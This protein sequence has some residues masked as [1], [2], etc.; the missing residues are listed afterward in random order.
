MDLCEEK[1]VPK[2][3]E[4]E[5][6]ILK[7]LARFQR[8]LLNSAVLKRGYGHVYRPTENSLESFRGLVDQEKPTF[9]II[10]LNEDWH[11]L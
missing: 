2:Q 10:L 9:S 8:R 5:V 6:L 11:P 1:E 7:M 4:E 3:N